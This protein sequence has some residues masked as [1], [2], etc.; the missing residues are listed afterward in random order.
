MTSRLGHAG[1]QRATIGK[2]YNIQGIGQITFN[3]SSNL[4]RC[5]RTGSPV[6]LGALSA[7]SRHKS[8]SDQPRLTHS[9]DTPQ[10]PK[11]FIEG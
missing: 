3:H 11:V 10:Q 4:A 6:A 2:T 9:I 1:S 7:D 5:R 8:L